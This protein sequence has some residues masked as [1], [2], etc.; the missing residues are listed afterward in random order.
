MKVE[1]PP[2]WVKEERNGDAWVLVCERCG[3][4][5]ARPAATNEVIQSELDSELK[6]RYGRKWKE[7]KDDEIEI[8]RSRQAAKRFESATGI[9][10]TFG[11]QHRACLPK[12]SVAS[13][14]KVPQQTLDIRVEPPLVKEIKQ[15]ASAP[16]A[17]RV[18]RGRPIEAMRRLK[19]TDFNDDWGSKRLKEGQERRYR[20][21]T[22]RMTRSKAVGKSITFVGSHPFAVDGKLVSV[23]G[24]RMVI[25][26]ENGQFVDL[27]VVDYLY[28]IVRRKGEREETSLSRKMSV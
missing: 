16:A 8:I 5:H 28:H 15:A 18:R 12:L 22:L 25:K 14:Q 27:D 7:A 21:F 1:P 3:K 6:Q 11:K 24:G 9:I 4:T 17:P 19:A 13:P 10:E 23:K 20:E 26:M 2:Q